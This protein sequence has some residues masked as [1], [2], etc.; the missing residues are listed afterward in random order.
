[1]AL[2]LD[3]N[4]LTLALGQEARS[5]GRGGLGL[6]KVPLLLVVVGLGEDVVIVGRGLDADVV[7]AVHERRLR[8]R[9]KRIRKRGKRRTG[10]G[11]DEP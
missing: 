11:D 3:G 10:R 2:L 4:A 5:E 8:L 1:M 7:H 6:L 9:K